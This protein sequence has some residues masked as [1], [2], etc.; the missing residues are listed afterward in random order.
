MSKLLLISTLFTFVSCGLPIEE[1]GTQEEQFTRKV[2][3]NCKGESKYSDFIGSWKTELKDKSIEL[4]FNEKFE[5]SVSI[6]CAK[7]NSTVAAGISTTYRASSAKLEISGPI[8]VSV[9]GCT[10]E[11]F[12]GD[13]SY[14]LEGS[15][16]KLEKEKEILYFINKKDLK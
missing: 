13:Y 2:S 9:E 12:G 5:I 4:D 7:G 16:L 6:A 14:Q 8:N 1:K 10:L 11:D 15:C 3:T